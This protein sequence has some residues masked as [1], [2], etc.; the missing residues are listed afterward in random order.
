MTFGNCQ[1]CLTDLAVAQTVEREDYT[2]LYKSAGQCLRVW[3]FY[4]WVEIVLLCTI[5]PLLADTS[6]C[7]ALDGMFTDQLPVRVTSLHW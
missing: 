5:G 1:E 3:Y 2:Y 4:I 6:F 7:R